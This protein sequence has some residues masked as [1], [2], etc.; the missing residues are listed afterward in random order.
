MGK[1]ENYL[2]ILQDTAIRLI[3]NQDFVDENGGKR[4]AG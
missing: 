4:V 1:T 3:A 2:T